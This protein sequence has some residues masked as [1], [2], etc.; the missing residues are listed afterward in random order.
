ML[1]E[2]HPLRDFRN[3]LYMVWLH[4]NLPN[5]T[6][7]QYDIANVLVNGPKRM[8]IEAFRGVGKSW[9]TSAFVLWL[10][11][12]NPQLKIMV[13]SASKD[14]SDQFSTFCKQLINDMPVLHHLQP[15]GDQRDS[16]ISFDVGPATPDHS[17]SV[18]SVGIFGQL[19]GS[20]ADVIVADDIEVPNNSFTPQMRHKLA[21]AVKEFDAILKP[22]PTSRIVYLGTPQTEESLYNQ[23]PSRGYQTFIWPARVPT[24]KEIAKYGEKLARYI[25]DLGKKL[26]AGLTTDPQRFSDIDL[27][28]REASYGRSGFVLQ[29]MLDTS[30]SDSERYPLKLS[31]LLVMDLDVEKAPVSVIWSGSPE[32]LDNDVPAIGFTGDLVHRPM[33]IDKDW[34]P[35]TGAVMFIDP[36][37]R[38]GDATGVAVVKYLHGKLFL[39]YAKGWKGGYDDE[40]LEGI[41]KVARDQKVNSV[42]IE[43]NF[44]DGMFMKLLTPWMSKHHKCALEEIR[45]SSQK[46]LR[47]I[48]TLEPVLNQHRLVVDRELL[49]RESTVKNENER[50]YLLFYQMTR[51]TKERGS[52]GHDDVLEAV[53]G[54]VAFWVESM[55]RDEQKALQEHK[56]KLLEKELERFHEHVTGYAAGNSDGELSEFLC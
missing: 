11:L 45:H 39:T 1:P 55:A 2:N 56:Q 22:L 9:I 41:A 31:D 6:E 8:V 33:M 44:G 7:L 52:L 3:F 30:L 13:V 21:E 18:K 53:A 37:G 10:L 43:S 48:D 15:S 34:Q 27:M 36:S 51:I 47:I 12:N 4:L 42:L 29:F 24:P 46:E 5:P 40:T 23:L 28:E 38:G 17:P 49:R 54:A 35:Y 16:K 26:K 50:D 20:R 25:I 19:A 14:R 32:Y